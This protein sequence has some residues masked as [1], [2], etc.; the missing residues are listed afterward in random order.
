MDQIRESI[1]IAAFNRMEGPIQHICF[2]LEALSLRLTE[3]I[4]NRRELRQ[5]CNGSESNGSHIFQQAPA[6]VD[7]R[8]KSLE[9]ARGTNS[10]RDSF[11]NWHSLRLCSF[12]LGMARNSNHRRMAAATKGALHM[13]PY[14]VL[15]SHQRRQYS[16]EEAAMP[17]FVKLD[18]IQDKAV[19]AENICRVETVSRKE[20]SI[21][22][23]LERN[24]WYRLL[25]ESTL[26]SSH[27]QLFQEIQTHEEAHHLRAIR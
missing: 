1:P 15:R 24:G 22:D 8:L 13:T 5:D 3:V 14:D 7:K 11:F 27:W 19:S 16:V 21:G 6:F 17:R 25:S 20:I 9:I 23:V 26:S 10:E 18:A 4:S 12:S 2:V